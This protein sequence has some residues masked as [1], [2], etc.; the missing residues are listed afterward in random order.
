MWYK[1]RAAL[2]AASSSSR[3]AELN[4]STIAQEQAMRMRFAERVIL[5]GAERDMNSLELKRGRGGLVAVAVEVGLAAL[6][7]ACTYIA[8]AFVDGMK[9]WGAANGDVGTE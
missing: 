1:K 5:S 4:E 7:A 9:A 8:L 2:R 3:G 6:R